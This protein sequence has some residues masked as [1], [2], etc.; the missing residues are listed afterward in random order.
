MCAILQLR[1][2][3]RFIL[4]ACG[5]PESLDARPAAQRFSA[6]FKVIVFIWVEAQVVHGESK[7]RR[8]RRGLAFVFQLLS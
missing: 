6:V 2:R 4:G 7:E 8:H 5:S 3:E 1:R